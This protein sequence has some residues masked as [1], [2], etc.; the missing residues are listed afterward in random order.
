[1]GNV[2]KLVVRAED[3]LEHTMK[4]Y[5]DAVVETLPRRQSSGTG[6]NVTQWDAQTQ[7]A[8][9]S[10]LTALNGVASNPSGMAICYNVPYLNNQTGV[11]EADLRLYMVSPPTGAFANIASSNVQVSLNYNG[12]TVSP[13]N[14]SSLKARGEQ[15]SDLNSLISWPRNEVVK[16]VL[17]PTLVQ[18]YAFV[19][20]INND[21]WSATMASSVL[22]TILVPNVTLSGQ[23]SAGNLVYTPLSSKEATFVTGLFPS[24][25]QEVMPSTTNKAQPPLQTLVVTDGSDFVLPG[26]SI[27]IFPIGAIITGLWTILFCGTIAYGTYGRM[28]FR[29]Q[30]RRRTATAEKGD[31]ARI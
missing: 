11:F 27:L 14:A 8:C 21:V 22:Q 1:M 7:A 26:F 15:E 29:E 13:V 16:R 31:L 6:L 17:T 4:R 24:A 9:T 3:S 20:Q 23:D 2:G 18:S 28:Q 19:G 5:V 25:A 12:A 30:F 10:A